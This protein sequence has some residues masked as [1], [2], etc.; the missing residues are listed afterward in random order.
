MKKFIFIIFS[1]LLISQLKAEELDFNVAREL[2]NKKLYFLAH[3]KFLQIEEGDFEPQIKEKAYFYAALSSY[4]NN[5]YKN[6]LFEFSLLFLNFPDTK[7]SEEAEYYSLNSLFFIKNFIAVV[8]SGKKFLKKYPLSKFKEKV[9]LLIGKSLYNMKYYRASLKYLKKVK[10]KDIIKESNFY[11]G[12]S[13]FALNDIDNAIA[14]Y[15]KVIASNNNYKIFSYLKLLKIYQK[16]NDQ[17]NFKNIL[18]KLE[19]V[20]NKSSIQN[21][22]DFIL[23]LNYYNNNQLD[24]AYKYIRKCDFNDSEV[25]FLYSEILLKNKKLEEA[26]EILKKLENY[27]IDKKRKTYIYFNKGIIEFNNNEFE[28]ALESFKKALKYLENNEFIFNLSNF[29]IA[30]ILFLNKTADYKPYLL[31]INRPDILENKGV[32]FDY[33]KM[34]GIYFYNL[35]EYRK[36]ISYLSKVVSKYSEDIYYM[37]G[38]S[39]YY[40]SEFNKANKYLLVVFRKSE[41]YDIKIFPYILEMN[42]KKLQFILSSFNKIKDRLSL[43][44]KKEYSFKIIEMLLNND[45]LDESQKFFNLLIS[46]KLN[47]EE[48]KKLD[49]LLVIFYE[50][51]NNLKKALENINLLINNAIDKDELAQFYFKKYE[52]LV[53]LNN[54]EAAKK[55]LNKI[56]ELKLINNIYYKKAVEI[57]K[58]Y[59]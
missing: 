14:Y 40:L 51:K 4:Y 13:Y 9:Y 10:D 6:A 52:I 21:K 1:I 28:I 11:I 15:K 33:N 2:F 31:R 43:S 38:M 32:I 35:R 12:N 19:K 44:L 34:M 49:Y 50:K 24:N 8:R 16:K 20:T 29:F 36:A 27:E 25:L 41:V 37:I 58:R 57:L 54:D 7:Y 45:N 39:Y 55:E 30:K 59:E 22:I 46:F 26:Y 17:L 48:K 53:K 3:E 5:G 18:F 42:N 47:N 56:I 23:A